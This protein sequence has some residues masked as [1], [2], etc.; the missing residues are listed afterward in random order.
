MKYK[1]TG[2]IDL[3]TFTKIILPMIDNIQQVKKKKVKM[4]LR[5]KYVH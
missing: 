3:F 1:L 4:F 2:L 5:I